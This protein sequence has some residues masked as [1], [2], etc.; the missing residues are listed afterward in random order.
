MSVRMHV[1][2]K[3]VIEYGSEGFAND[4]YGIFL[5]LKGS[6]C[7]I[8]TDDECQHTGNVWEIDAQQFNSAV[9]KIKTMSDEEVTSYFNDANLKKADIV[10]E[11][12]SF[13]STGS[14]ADGNYHFSW[15]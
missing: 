10:R 9:E 11:L 7:D 3:H 15:F 6:G 8:W 13:I 12:E 5:L 2:K 1:H 14:A 4:S